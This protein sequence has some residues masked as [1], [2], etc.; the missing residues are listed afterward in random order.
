[1]NSFESASF[2]RSRNS[3]AILV[4][5]YFGLLLLISSILTVSP[6]LLPNVGYTRFFDR[7]HSVA[8]SGAYNDVASQVSN[9]SAFAVVLLLLLITLV[10]F[11]W[12]ILVVIL[13]FKVWGMTNDV[14]ALKRHI[15][16]Y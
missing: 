12:P 13:F 11:V 3:G 4:T 2:S 14:K 10:G 9:M 8:Q 7:V 16:G 5:R 1:M 6:P 15:C